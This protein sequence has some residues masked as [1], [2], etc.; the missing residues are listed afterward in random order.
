MLSDADLKQIYDLFD[1]AVLAKCTSDKMGG[2]QTASVALALFDKIK[3][4]STVVCT[5][6]AP[7]ES[8]K[9]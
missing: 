2:M 9:E 4:M 3:L 6:D 8:V 5:G 7:N 1:M